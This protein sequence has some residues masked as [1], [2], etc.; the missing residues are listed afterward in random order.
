LLTYNYFYQLLNISGVKMKNYIKIFS[1]LLILVL[2]N[3]CG[4]NKQF[5]EKFGVDSEKTKPGD[6]ITVYYNPDST[7]LK[8]LQNIECVAYLYNSE[9]INA[10]DVPLNKTSNFWKG[11]FKTDEKAFGV[12]FNF[13][14]DEQKDNNNKSGYVIYLKNENGEDVPGSIA[15]YAAAIN[16]W[17]AYYLDLDRDRE[18][19]YS[20]FEKEFS[21]NPGIKDQFL[22]PYFEVVSLVE[23]EKQNEI[24]KK[25][26]E[27]LE[28]K[29]SFD[30]K[31]L[32][33]LTTWYGKI[34]DDNKAKEYSDKLN[35][36]FPQNELLQVSIYQQFR[37]ESDISKKIEMMKKFEKNF[38]GIEYTSVMYD[39][40]ANAYRDAGNYPKA[41]EFLNE[42][43]SKPSVY[44]FYAVSKK[45][46]DE[47]K[48]LDIADKIAKL[49]IDRARNEL[50]NPSEKKPDFESESEWKEEREYYL[51]LNLYAEGKILYNL[52]KKS[53]CLPVV[54]EAVQLT[55]SKDGDMNELYSR[56]LV[57]NGKYE[58][59]MEKI[60][61]FIEKGNSTSVMK[62]LLKEA[63][64]NEKGTE[65]G[66]GNYVE[67][68]EN[69]AKEKMIED[70][71]NKMILE[72]A[73][74]FSL[75]DLNGNPISLEDYKGKTVVLD[76]WAT[77]CGP[78]LAS[79]PGMK[80][81]VE[82]YKDNDNV[83]F[84]FVDAWERVDDK[85]TNA[86]QF[87]EKNNYPFHVLLDEE[88]SVIE[89]YKVSGIPT[90]F[91]IDGS[92]NIRFMNVGYDGPADKLVE[93]ISTMISLV[94]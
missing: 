78:C 40:V 42:N 29:S 82:K 25:D 73:P 75:L 86:G 23:A 34:G 47:N 9:L 28:Q 6:E 22:S 3:A 51:A 71:K 33:L 61:G 12:I 18:K 87:I 88:N 60:S 10:I 64:L 83:K 35:S 91:I 32:E 54:E 1:P 55:D 5:K 24:I 4:P 30:E 89:Q 15:G 72:P 57:E 13:K 26:L 76:F 67:K 94:Q 7:D 53:E 68:Y 11:S 20:L 27:S 48:D 92:G 8:G 81:A 77:W 84:L 49:G 21:K 38:S 46:I 93:E 62:N 59:A 50:K 41:Y 17:G 74:Q 44:R 80:D 65:E 69:T 52:E 16:R 56:A 45:M 66:F 70:L 85:K 90:K 63:Y 36:Q 37:N 79:F 43:V 2:I 39:L 14:S 19:A 31:E 58:I